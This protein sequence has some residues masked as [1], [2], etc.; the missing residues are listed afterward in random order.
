MY[1]HIIRGVVPSLADRFADPLDARMPLSRLPRPRPTWI[2]PEPIPDDADLLALH[3]HR[4]VASLLYRRGIRTPEDASAFL[5]R[6]EP[7]ALEPD[8]L[9]NMR[10]ALTR[11]AMAIDNGETIGIFGDYDADGVTSTTL[12]TRAL[13]SAAG[14]DKVVPFVPDRADGYGVSERGVRMLAQ[15]G[16]TLMIAVDCG[17]NDIE[18]VALAR[19][20][21]MDVIILDH[22]ALNGNGPEGAILVSAQLRADGTYRE[23]TGVGI[24]WLFVLGLMERGYDITRLEGG[25]AGRLLDLVALGTVADVGALKGANRPLVGHGLH[26]LRAAERPGVRALLRHGQMEPAAITADRISFGLA[27][28]LNA[29][30]RVASASAALELLLT[31]DRD[32]ADRL[33][34]Q[35]EQWNQQR[36]ERTDHILAEIAASI[37]A[38]PGW[39][40]KPFLALHGPDWDK[41]L[42]GPIAA[43]ITERLGV[44]VVIMQEQDGVLSGSGRS[45]PGVNLL[46]ALRAA[47]GLMTRYG[48][49]SG[50]A[51]L[52][53][54]REHLD[55]FTAAV[56][57][58]VRAQGVPL[59]QPPALQ[60]H[61]WLPEV[62]Q[63]VSIVDALEHLEPFGQDNPLP[64][65]GVQGARILDIRTM[66][67][68]KQHLKISVGGRRRG[69]D[70]ILWGGAA[71]AAEL[72]G[73]ANVDLAGT[74][75]VNTWNGVKRLQ[76]ILSD[77][78]RA[79]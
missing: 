39:A 16:C 33:A 35:L 61:A 75:S 19:G 59:P 30:G 38:M 44:P 56:T 71:R 7:D 42:V 11:T 29:A 23:L 24:A 6:R 50:A 58:A 63:Q 3:P 74:L 64:L 12:L 69:L 25:D 32:L 65:F 31:D 1:G 55:A 45:V 4:L 14:E 13:R 66:G 57:D 67:R 51:G 53:L 78:R 8:L 49:H 77:F 60:L 54:P 76:M 2:E 18:A 22:H 40:E 9:P 36:R 72:R 73:A 48:G 41:G 20:L 37:G 43:K 26:R 62:A 5:T 52:T 27:P 68:E 46:E 21:G 34:M 47:D 10:E 28:R 15:T 17:S 79:S 70:A